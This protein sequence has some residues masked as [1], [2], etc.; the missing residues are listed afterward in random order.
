MDKRTKGAW[1]IHHGKK[2]NDNVNAAAEYSALDLAAK[3]ASL[4]SRM[5]A[6]EETTLDSEKVK[7]LGKVGG[8]NPKLEL[9]ACLEELR[10]QQ[11]IDISKDGSVAVLGITSE[12]ALQHAADL[13]E[14]NDP[15]KQEY[16]AIEL[17]ELVSLSPEKTSKISEFVSDTFSLSRDKA[18][19]LLAQSAS[20]GFVDTDE[21][22]DDP[23]LYNGNL[24]R[25]DSINKTKKVLESLT[26]DEQMRLTEFDE[27]LKSAG[28]IHINVAEKM[29]GTPL[30]SK[31]RAAALYDENIVSNEAGEHS[32]ITSPSSFH[33]FNNP[34]LDDAFD[35]AK[36][37][38]SALSYGMSVSSNARGRIWGVDL[39]LKKLI[40]GS[41]VG[42]VEAIGKDYRALELERVV[43]IRP[44][45]H[46]YEMRLLKKEVGE[47]ALQ[48]LSKGSSATVNTEDI[49]SAQVIGYT[50][51]EKART[52][53]KKRKS[54][55]I[56]KTQ[57]RTLL[58]SVRSGGG[59]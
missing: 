4:L 5:A 39:I 9:N 38:V 52:E 37:L 51:P 6:S 36:A 57:M 30:L 58:S 21:D 26:G 50:P 13:F 15:E 12:T 24:F 34:M 43:Q 17:S 29:L 35:H 8:L 28:A 18:S 16:A 14:R 49:P 2:L 20:I 22:N 54:T 48:V 27:K 40:N 46:R 32:F 33:K 7:T 44:V 56:S 11:V 45:G 23:L 1:I 3:S 53:F 25:R 59:L 42:P 55:Q 47:I 41:S 31:L 19:D 10:K